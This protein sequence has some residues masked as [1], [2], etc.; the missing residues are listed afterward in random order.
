VCALDIIL[1]ATA[2]APPPPPPPPPL[3]YYYYYCCCCTEQ[4]NFKFYNSVM[5]NIVP[6]K[7]S[8]CVLLADLQKRVTT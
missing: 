6:A 1:T 4:Q 2:A 8:S 5:N 7:L 3:Q